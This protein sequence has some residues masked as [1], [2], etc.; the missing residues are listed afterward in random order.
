MQVK[1]LRVLE[2]GTFIHVGGSEQKKVD[3][4]I[5]AATNKNLEQMVKDGTFREDL[6]Y[7][8]NVINIRLPALKERKEDIPLLVNKFLEEYA[9]QN[10]LPLKKISTPCM[11]KMEK[12]DWPGNVREL[13]NEVERLCVLSGNDIK[14]EED[15]LSEKI[16]DFQSSSKLTQINFTGNLKEALLELEKN[17]IYESLIEFKWNKSRAATKLGIS[18]ANLIMKCEKFGFKKEG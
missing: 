10:K 14:I 16:L 9:N 11:R 18:R 7:R 6:Y 15:L 8:L 13:K 4:R 5:L 1:L 12:Y 17:M 2:E 3:V